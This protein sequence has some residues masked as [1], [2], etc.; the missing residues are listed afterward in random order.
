MP[1]IRIQKQRDATKL[2]QNGPSTESAL[3]KS[4]QGPVNKNPSI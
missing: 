1:Y 2:K 4:S 3:C